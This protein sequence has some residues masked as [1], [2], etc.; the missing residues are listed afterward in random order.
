MNGTE[1]TPPELKLRALVPGAAGAV[2]ITG[3]STYV[4]LRLRRCRGRRFSSR[5]S[6]LP[7]WDPAAEASGRPTRR[8]QGC[9]RV[10]LLREGLPFTLPGLWMADAGGVA[11]LVVRNDRHRETLMLVASGFLGGEGIAGVLMAIWKV[12]TPWGSERKE[13]RCEFSCGACD[14]Q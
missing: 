6:V 11:A 5:C 13:G 1:K 7:S 4:A 12:V 14:R 9:P 10:A 2:I 3:S 8:T